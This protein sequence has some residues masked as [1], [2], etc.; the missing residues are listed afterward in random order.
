ME[1]IPMFAN[2]FQTVQEWLT[3]LFEHISFINVFTFITGIVFGIILSG[4][5]YLIIIMTSIK[6]EQ[7]F[8]NKCDTTVCDDDI[9]K[10][11][12]SAQN[13][14][15]EEAMS[16][17]TSEK[18]TFIKNI[19]W[20]LINDIAKLHYPD[21][22]YPIYELSIDELLMLNHYITKRIEHIFEGKFLH[23]AKKVKISTIVKYMDMKKKID[24]N[25][26]VKV[27]QTTTH[28]KVV[29]VLFATLNSLNPVFW[30]KKL[31]TSAILPAGMNKI[32]TLII[33]IV[34]EETK[35]VYSK[36]AF[37]EDEVDT[38][39]KKTI[40]VLENQIEHEMK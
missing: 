40:E 35:R 32:A 14:Y 11:I 10:V 26:L 28:S 13:V 25:K 23:K 21:S 36:N 9:R 17:N 29:K 30:M 16:L 4:L 27:A 6:R 39:M 24:E 19:S 8:I 12:L 37:I 34:G 31:F 18:L 22:K 38:E 7:R 3:R 2:F 5:I 15:R 20:D 1:G 33:D